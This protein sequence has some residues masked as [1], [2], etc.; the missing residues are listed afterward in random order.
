M[1]GSCVTVTDV[2]PVGANDV[3]P[4]AM[5]VVPNVIEELVSAELGM[6]VN[7]LVE[8]LIDLFV[9]VSVVAR[10]TKVSVLVGK[11]KTPVLLI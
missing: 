4:N 10:P 1:V 3:P 8:P 2:K 9:S 7:V 5:L 11:V 6:L